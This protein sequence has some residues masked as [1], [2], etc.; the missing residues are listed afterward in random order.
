M[1]SLRHDY[2]QG[3]QTSTLARSTPGLAWR[4]GI[5]F[6]VEFEYA[7][8]SA[9]SLG[10]RANSVFLFLSFPIIPSDIAAEGIFWGVFSNSFTTSA[11]PISGLSQILVQKSMMVTYSES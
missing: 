5:L 6:P 8:G 7:E 4:V 1:S 2:V 9:V 11:P 3:E 10:G